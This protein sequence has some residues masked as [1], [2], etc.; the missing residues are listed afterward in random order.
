MMFYI[1]FQSISKSFILVYTESG[2]GGMMRAL[3]KPVLSVFILL[4]AVIMVGCSKLGD[5]S[6]APQGRTV[7][8]EIAR[9]QAAQTVSAQ[10][11]EAAERVS[12]TVRIISP[13][14]TDTFTPQPPTLTPTMTSTVTNTATTIVLQSPTPTSTDNFTPT[15]TKTPTYVRPTRTE[16]PPPYQCVLISK[17]PLTNTYMQPGEDFD[18]H[19]TIQNTGSEIWYVTEVIARYRN[20]AA[21]H[22]ANAYSLAHN[23]DPFETIT[24]TIDMVAPLYPGTYVAVWTL[25]RQ[26]SDFCWF[27]VNIVVYQP[28]E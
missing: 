24:V 14:P 19:W 8:I 17:S 1:D 11:T 2:N 9:T 3:K 20:G 4:V 6:P 25:S 27:S 28:R 12:P 5:Q 21:I 10:M 7:T 13:T 16:V 15:P 26:G 18:G 23:V 22:K